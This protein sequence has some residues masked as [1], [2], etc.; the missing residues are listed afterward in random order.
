MT[1]FELDNI[2]SGMV[3]LEPGNLI[4]GIYIIELR[5]EKI[6]RAKIIIK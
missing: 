3:E 1:V 2:M 6:I 4:P 5:G